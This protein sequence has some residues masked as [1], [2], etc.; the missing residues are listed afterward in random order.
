MA[1]R[2]VVQK[3]TAATLDFAAVM[4]V[5]SRI[6]AGYEKQ[7]PGTAARMRAAA[8]AA[9]RWALANPAVAYRQP[10]DVVTGAYGDR[11]LADEFVWAATELY[12]LTGDAAYLQEFTQRST[13]PGVMGVPSWS[14]VG[15]LALVS[16]AQARNRLPADQRARVETEL[17]ALA[18]SWPRNGSTPPGRWRCSQG[19]SY[20]AAT[21]WC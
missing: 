5:A 14:D 7:F 10:A 19:I 2:Y 8:E 4:A 12:L 20:G 21:P 1:R 18:A 3:T 16:L 15:G 17:D 13:T 6:H 9:W 11:V